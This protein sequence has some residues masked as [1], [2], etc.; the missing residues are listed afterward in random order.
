MLKKS[1]Q[2]ITLIRW[3]PGTFRGSPLKHVCLSQSEGCVTLIE[4]G[5][6]WGYAPS[7][8]LCSFAYLFFPAVGTRSSAVLCSKALL[9]KFEAARKNLN[10]VK[11]LPPYFFLFENNY[12]KRTSK[13]SLRKTFP[14]AYLFFLAVS[15]SYAQRNSLRSL[16][17]QE[18]TWIL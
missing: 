7:T 6:W 15:T 11:N 18:K 4:E 16:R 1:Y 2:L 13:V 8:Y 14:H 5:N 3:S 12:Q 17:Q 10:F 9:K